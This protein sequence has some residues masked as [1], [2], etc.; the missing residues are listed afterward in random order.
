MEFETKVFST[1]TI[2]PSSP[3]P[4]SLQK[5]QLS[6]LDQLAPPS[7]MPFVYFYSSN[8]IPN[9]QKSNHLKNSL[10]QVLSI[11]YPLAGRLVNNLYVDCHNGGA[12]FSEAEADCDLSQ[13]ITN[14]DPKNMKKFLPYKLMNESQDFCMAVQATYFRCGGLAVGLLIS[15]TISDALSFFFFANAWSTVAR[16]GDGGGIQLPKFDAATYFPPRDISGFKPSTGMILKE[17]L[18][19]KIFTFP[20]DKITLLRERYGGGDVPQR[21][22]TRVEA[23]SAFIWTRFVSATGQKADPNKIYTVQH[24]INLRTRI[25]PPLPEYHFGNIWR[26]SIAKPE[27]GDGGVKL[28]Q[29]VWEAMKAVNGSYVAQLKEGHEKHLNM[30]KELMAQSNKGELVSFSFTSLCRFPLY[31]ADFGWGKPVQVGSAGFVYK[32]LVTFMD[33]TNGDG[34]EA[35][36]NLRKEDMEK[37]EADFELQEFLSHH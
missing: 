36:I 20:A 26:V 3:T 37:F 1:E 2:K 12:P 28:L 17:E 32:N 16:N 31:E 18:V 19:T 27:V 21:R 15:H 24:A 5:H 8:T 22:P 4:K 11:F 34:I 13:V 6:F 7:L 14:L 25:E 9:S 23:L 10:S 33:T 30:M 29:K 35:W